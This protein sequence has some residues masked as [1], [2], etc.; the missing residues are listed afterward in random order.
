[1]TGHGQSMKPPNATLT[2]APFDLHIL[3]RLSVTESEDGESLEAQIAE[4]KRDAAAVLGVEVERVT[5][6]ESPTLGRPADAA[7]PAVKVSAGYI[8]GGSLW[9]QRQDLR[10]VLDDARAG[11]CRAVLTPNLDRVARN[12]EVAER[13]KRELL[14]AGVR[15]LYEGRNALDLGDDNQNLMYGMR[16]TFSAY[17]RAVITRRNFSGHIRAAREGFYV[18]G[19]IPFGTM[20][21]PTGLRSKSRRYRMVVDD[22]EMSTVHRLFAMRADGASLDDL[23][24]WTQEN[25]VRPNPYHYLSRGPGLTR[26]HIEYIL[27]NEFYVTGC[28]RFS[29]SAP[30]WPSE[31]VEQ[32]LDLPKP[33]SRELFDQLA[34]RR[35]R[36]IGE[37]QT[38][39]AYVLSGLVYHCDSNTAF[40]AATTKTSA[41]RYHYYYNPAWGEARRALHAEGK[42][43]TAALTPADGN[44]P[45]YAS[46]PKQTLESL[47]LAELARLAERPTLIAE[48]VTAAEE[49]S[50]AERSATEDAHLRKL[51]VVNDAQAAVERFLEAFASGVLP[52]TP[53]TTRKHEELRARVHRLEAEARE[54]N[55]ARLG[56]LT[57]PDGAERIQKALASLPDRLGTAQPRDQVTLVRALVSRVWVDSYGQVSIDLALG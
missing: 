39:G 46:I 41:R 1:M 53:E 21:T 31:V 20:L 32:Y 48:L 14:A 30:R 27:K 40:R 45:V 57:L 13:F 47:V 56:G 38:A 23:V 43:T 35:A 19:N 15:T 34:A 51:A 11:R 2:A 9:E 18:G 28:F 33:V 8:S 26:T 49:G 16:A 50:A 3:C 24:G 55:R 54:L 52:M 44:H 42:L 37:R 4:A 7:T 12:V 22:E 5:F 29:I 10:D 36:R 6:V 17:E 25:G